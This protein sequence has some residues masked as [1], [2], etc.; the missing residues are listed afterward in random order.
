MKFSDILERLQPLVASHSLTLLP[1][2]NPD[3]QGVSPIEA[4]VA[5]SLSYI[6][7]DKFAPFVKETPV[8]ALILPIDTALQSQAQQRGIAWLATAQPRLAFAQAI[9]LFYKPYQPPAGI[10]PTAVIDPTVILGQQV[11]IGAHVVIQ[12][13]STIGDQVCIHPNVV[14][15]PEVT[16]GERTVLHANCVIHE[17]SQIGADCMIHSGAVIGAEGFGFVP[18]Q[19]G[20]YKMEQSGFVV[21][22]DGVEVGCNSS[23]DRP[24]VGETRV[25]RNTKIDNL[26][27]IGHGCT[28][29]T[30][31][32]IAAQTGLAGG[33]TL[34]D[35]VILA[36]QVGVANQAHIGDGVT[37]GA[38]A[39]IHGNVAAG[40]VVMG[41]PAVSYNLFL[42]ASAIYHRL[43][44]M[45]QTYRRLQ[46]RFGD[47]LEKKSR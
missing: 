39:G 28:I 2:L 45:Y 23:I 13:G 17:R 47:D 10:H 29:G 19:E 35:R 32:A 46:R 31:G 22:E 25:G 27:Q 12:A 24:A 21:L 3:V 18:T 9:A 20:W 7:G 44:E 33:T 43:P 30:N 42:K 26:V 40:Q 5:G 8:S 36:G 41:Y 16:I 6:E 38:K 34:G 11:A 4:A 15:Y 1:D 37:A 14:L